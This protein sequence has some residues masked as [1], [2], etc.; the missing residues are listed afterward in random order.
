MS[1]YFVIVMYLRCHAPFPDLIESRRLALVSFPVQVPAF[2]YLHSMRMFENF[3]IIDVYSYLLLVQ[4]RVWIMDTY[5]LELEQYHQQFPNDP[6]P[7]SPTA[8]RVPC[9]P[10]KHVNIGR[11]HQIMAWWIS[12]FICATIY[13]FW[14]NSTYFLFLCILNYVGQID[15]GEL[16]NAQNAQPTE[17]ASC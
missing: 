5:E 7:P 11:Q 3:Q 17:R 9:E 12:N 14:T 10:S 13:I 15:Q 4:S 1:Q 2:V 16:C 8:P 6:H